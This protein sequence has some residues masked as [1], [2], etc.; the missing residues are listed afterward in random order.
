MIFEDCLPLCIVS[1]SAVMMHRSL[2]DLAGLFDEKLPACED[3]DLWL[4][5]SCRYPIYLIDTPLIIKR[6]GHADQLSK[7]SRLDRFRIQ[8]LQKLLESDLLTESQYDKALQTLIYKCRIYSKG[9]FKHGRTQEA[10]YYE[11]LP[12]KYT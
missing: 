7:A 11:K 2:F 12:E 10:D 6:G 1:P 8:A 4:R 5:I 3:Y 9:C